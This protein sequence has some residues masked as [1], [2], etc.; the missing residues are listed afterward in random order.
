ML[1]LK[2]NFDYYS[3]LQPKAEFQTFIGVPVITTDRLQSKTLILL[4][5]VDHKSLET[6]ILITI[7]CP[8]DS[9]WQSKILFLE[10]LYLP[11]TIVKI[12]AYV[13]W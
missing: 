13:V 10:I 11:S 7:C 3:I 4:T 5:N 1:S 9:K 8:T 2:V 6:E 12:A